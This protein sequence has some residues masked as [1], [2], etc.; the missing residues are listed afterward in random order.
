MLF[1]RLIQ[2][3]FEHLSLCTT[4]FV[5]DVL[6]WY[7][8]TVVYLT[9]SQ[10]IARESGND[11]AIGVVCFL[12]VFAGSALLPMAE[13]N[14]LGNVSWR[15][16]IALFGCVACAFFYASYFALDALAHG[17]ILVVSNI[18]AL[19]PLSTTF[20]MVMFGGET[21]NCT[22]YLVVL[23]AIFGVVLSTYDASSYA[24][25]FTR[26]AMGIILV[27]VL[28]NFCYSL[29]NVILHHARDL[30]GKSKIT[31][32]IACCAMAPIPASVSFGMIFATK[33][34]WPENLLNLDLG[35]LGTSVS[36]FVLYNLASFFVLM[37]TSPTT[38]AMLLIGKR[39]VTV[40]L[41]CALVQEWPTCLQLIGLTLT[42]VAVKLFESAKS[43][44]VESSNV[45]A[46]AR[47]VQIP[48]VNHFQEF[49]SS[50]PALTACAFA[51]CFVC[52]GVA[53]CM[54]D[55]DASLSGT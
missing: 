45:R 10:E 8:A 23:L 46:T 54:P 52:T 53:L 51:L 21:L 49:V 4:V 29:R 28:A 25:Q 26:G 41:A 1:P 17:G 16:S 6:V 12:Q 13:I 36:S 2:Y 30:V 55:G 9:T 31:L 44:E 24:E 33:P 40:L 50:P 22:Q 47:T 18:R 42:A 35:L 5:I 14:S 48:K 15:L 34:E 7:F 38:H 27:L 39:I 3:I 20:L 43:K 37:S 19:E 11:V 32:F